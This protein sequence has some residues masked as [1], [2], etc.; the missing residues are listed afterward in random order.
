M[1]ECSHPPHRLF[2]GDAMNE[3]GIVSMWIACCDCGEVLV[4]A[5]NSFDSDSEH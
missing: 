5:S 1:T 4:P 3:H 2:C